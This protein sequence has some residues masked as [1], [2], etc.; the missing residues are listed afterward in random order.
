MAI[1]ASARKFQ[2]LPGS[3]LDTP[4]PRPGPPVY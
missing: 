4:F 2:A 3:G 1:P